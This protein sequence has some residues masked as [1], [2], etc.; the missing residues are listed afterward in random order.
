MARP[1]KDHEQINIKL[2]KT[3]YERLCA[4]CDKE[5]RTKTSA[6]ERA[7]AAYLDKYESEAKDADTAD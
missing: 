2:D 7:L 1:R 5:D 6:I 3:L 4:H